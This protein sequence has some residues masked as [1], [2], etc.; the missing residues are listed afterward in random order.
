MQTSVMTK[1]IIKEKIYQLERIKGQIILILERS[2]IR[3][4]K[5]HEITVGD[6]RVIITKS[7][8][9]KNSAVKEPSN[10]LNKNPTQ[11]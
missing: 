1:T 6:I 9:P 3:S 10:I 8:N 2:R 4:I 11:K 7:L 5:T